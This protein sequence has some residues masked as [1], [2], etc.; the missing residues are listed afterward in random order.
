MPYLPW[1]RDV[2]HKLAKMRGLISI[3]LLSLVSLVACESEKEIRLQEPEPSEGVVVDSQVDESF[4]TIELDYGFKIV[5]GQKEDFQS[6]VTFSRLELSRNGN[7]IYFD[8]TLTEYQAPNDMYPIFSILDTNTFE[9]LLEVN[10]RPSRNYL[11]RLIISD[12]KV[13]REDKLPSFIGKPIEIF[14]NGLE[15]YFGYWDYAQVWGEQNE[16]TAYN[17]LLVYT[18][19]ENGL[20]LDS[21]L[22]IRQNEE[23]YGQFN[24]YR[25]SESFEV[26]VESLEKFNKHIDSLDNLN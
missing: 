12:G 20:T 5:F 2:M 13:K 8:S 4:E 3:I 7:L 26:P 16:L 14:G 18:S 24:G 15:Y 23:I 25:F 22:T 17:P 21:L 11:K 1:L 9:I 6:F 10:D 19:S